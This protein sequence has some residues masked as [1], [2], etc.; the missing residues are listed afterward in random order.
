MTVQLDH[1]GPRREAA[2]GDITVE[3]VDAIVNA[4]T[5]R[6]SAAGVWMGPSTGLPVL[7]C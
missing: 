2:L 5:R 1:A 6:C 3:R 4:R 7:S